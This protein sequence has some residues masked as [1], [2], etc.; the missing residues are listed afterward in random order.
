M[1]KGKRKGTSVH[2]LE[3]EAKDIQREVQKIGRTIMS[4]PDM[5]ILLGNSIN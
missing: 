4:Y 5:N 3:E 2:T 1:K